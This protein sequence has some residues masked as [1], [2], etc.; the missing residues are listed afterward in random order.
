[1]LQQ[2]TLHRARG[3]RYTEWAT[4]DG[5]NLRPIWD[6]L[7][8]VGLYSHDVGEGSTCNSKENGCFDG[9]ENV[10]VYKTHPDVVANL[11]TQI[12]AIVAQRRPNPGGGAAVC[13]VGDPTEARCH[14]GCPIKETARIK[15]PLPCLN[16]YYVTH[17]YVYRLIFAIVH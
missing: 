15:V 10:N 16:M 2:Q 12:H 3:W 11:S 4:W 13:V 7:V 8:G 14:G 17:V 6:K 1:M 5:A 9:F